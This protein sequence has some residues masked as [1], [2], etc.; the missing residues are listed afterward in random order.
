[1]ENKKESSDRK[2]N[3]LSIEQEI[4][5][6]KTPEQLA[7]TCDVIA[8]DAQM[9]YDYLELSGYL[10]RKCDSEASR[11]KDSNLS[12]QWKQIKTQLLTDYYSRALNLAQY[13][14]SVR[15]LAELATQNLEESVTGRELY[16]KALNYASEETLATLMIADS[17]CNI[18]KDYD[19]AIKICCDMMDRFTGIQ[20]K[21]LDLEDE[22]TRAL[23]EDRS[24]KE[25][26]W[27]DVMEKINQ[28]F[29]P[30]NQARR[31]FCNVS[32]S[33]N[34]HSPFK[35]KNKDGESLTITP[36]ECIMAI[37]E[38]AF[39]YKTIVSLKE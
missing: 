33:F 14:P 15:L 2:N 19:W 12:I 6:A 27:G 1:M 8:N 35:T 4:A 31:T 16:K 32:T 34:W 9:F 7:N 39:K 22:C 30:Y 37:I 28:T 26:D 23:Q 21:I 3:D 38:T 36:K 20:R 13:A 18:L 17:V 11:I 25:P 24:E 5:G 10:I 29:E